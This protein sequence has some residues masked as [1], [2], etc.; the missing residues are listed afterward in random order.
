MKSKD[1]FAFALEDS[2]AAFGIRR[3]PFP[4]DE[5]DDFFFSTPTLGKQIDALRNLVNYSDLLL[6]I[7][8]VEG[9]GKT[10]FLNQ[11]LLAADGSW[12]YCRI[13][14]S[15]SMT[16]SSLVDELLTG[17]GLHARGDDAQADEALLLAH[18]VE[19][20]ANGE[21]A[22]LT[23]DDA[24][25]LPQI[26][27][28]FLLGLAEQRDDIDLRLLLT[29]EPGR[30]GF[31]THDSKRVHVVVLKPFDTQQSGDYLNSRL[32]YAGLVGDSPF[33]GSVVEDI[34]QDSGGLPG[35][36]HPCALHSLLASTDATRLRRRTP[37]TKRAI[38]YVALVLLI[39]A[40]AALIIGPE[41]G[42]DR[43]A[44]KSPGT[45]GKVEGHIATEAMTDGAGEA[46]SAGVRR[47]DAPSPGGAALGGIV[48][49]GDQTKKTNAEASKV[50]VANAG[51]DVK[52]FTLDEKGTSTTAAVAVTSPA[53]V[54][55]DMSSRSSEPITSFSSNVTPAATQPSE[56]Q[57]AHS[58]D[59]LR[60]Q[61]P[62]HYVIQLL[63]A[64]DASA[65]R[66]F[67]DTHKLG[68]KGTWYMTSHENK[69]WYV[70][71]YGMYPDSASARAAI[72]SLPEALRAG[73]PWPRSVANV[74]ES[75][76]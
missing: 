59:W 44:V 27:T 33:N 9:A 41:S 64:R 63:G 34:Y 25:L 68:A 39:G 74:V 49:A 5:T 29:T 55:G 54:K 35:A 7:S 16:I 15:T 52:V 46:K 61:D 19:V 69:P 28:E 6:V 13:D 43:V 45:T 14:G 56:P 8:G 30:I 65:V 60:E 11:F 38:A 12:K 47:Q 66:K 18:L 26:C 53:P 51:G 76:R 58:L 50:F 40:G 70:V 10:T 32:S 3:N 73:S 31:S 67:L 62:S 17:F 24:H 42:V 22:L 4:I 23:V 75:A 72:K 21:I 57:A 37:M 48:T 36:I 2:L 20:H 71:V 1:K